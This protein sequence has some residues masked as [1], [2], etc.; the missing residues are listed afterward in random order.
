MIHAEADAAQRPPVGRRAG[1]ALLRGS[2]PEVRE[3]W[4]AV[5]ERA[6]IDVLQPPQLRVVV[7]HGFAAIAHV[8]V[9][10][11]RRAEPGEAERRLLERLVQEDVRDESHVL[12]G[13]VRRFVVDA[14]APHGL[15]GVERP[16]LAGVAEP[17]LSGER[18]A[19]RETADV[20]VRRA[21]ERRH[22]LI[23]RQAAARLD[24]DVLLLLEVDEQILRARVV[25]DDVRRDDPEDVELVERGPRLGEPLRRDRI[26]DRERD[27]A[28]DRAPLR[29]LVSPH[30]DGAQPHEVA[31]LDRDPRVGRAVVEIRPQR[32]VGVE[33]AALP[34]RVRDLDRQ[35]LELGRLERSARKVAPVRAEDVE[36]GPDS[37]DRGDRR[38]RRARSLHDLDVDAR[39]LA[40]EKMGER[41]ALVELELL[42]LDLRIEEPL[43]F[44]EVA[45]RGER[46]LGGSARRD[47]SRDVVGSCVANRPPH[48]SLAESVGARHHDAPQPVLRARAHADLDEHAI[49][50]GGEID[51][52]LRVDETLRRVPA[53]DVVARLLDR[54]V[55]DPLVHADDRMP[56]DLRR[57]LRLLED[58]RPV[59]HLDGLVDV[60]SCRPPDLELRS[61]VDEH[62]EPRLIGAVHDVHLGLDE[63]LP[64][65]LV[66]HALARLLHGLRDDALVLLHALATE[67]AT[68][69]LLRIPVEE[70]EHALRLE[71]E[72][73]CHLH[74]L[75]PLRAFRRHLDRHVA[76]ELVA[77]RARDL[78]LRPR[79][80]FLCERG[81]EPLFQHELVLEVIGL[82][83]VESVRAFHD[84]ARGPLHPV[85]PHLADSRRRVHAVHEVHRFVGLAR[86]VDRQPRLEPRLDG[87]EPAHLEQEREVLADELQVELLP[88]AR[89]EEWLEVL[90][91]E[92]ALRRDQRHLR[93]LVALV[94]GDVVSASGEER[95]QPDEQRERASCD[96]ALSSAR[97]RA[98]PLDQNSPTVASGNARCQPRNMR[99]AGPPERQ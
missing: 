32:G 88:L 87:V 36:L 80:A 94:P 38:E 43:P 8:E 69:L 91:G 13:D 53:R 83:A 76:H 74:L 11:D 99:V 35:T 27:L 61:R 12:R 89:A 4:I 44:V 42:E 37:A 28:H 26:P 79:P 49:G 68:D 34:V 1:N 64:L 39:R 14:G 71:P 51:V 29:A 90:L 60:P 59:L 40:I 86:F 57:T 23:R 66:E 65:E 81:G 9:D 47:P 45:D 19:L 17:R 96:A 5:H 84:P 92:P 30:D 95:E 25:A 93:D 20:P 70:Q 3:P 10:A 33:V 18:Q 54:D 7:E 48:P 2:E 82:A 15:G 77:R 41:A 97:S 98:L 31:G 56:V 78:H 6:R 58:A 50:L 46:F 73:P 22:A 52:H 63:A 16:A 55:G 24:E 62:R 21:R 72:V 75:E 67:P 85:D